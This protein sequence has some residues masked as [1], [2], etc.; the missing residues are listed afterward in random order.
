[1]ITH[2]SPMAN[3]SINALIKIKNNNQIKILKIN[4]LFVVSTLIIHVDKQEMKPADII[5]HDQLQN[6]IALSTLFMLKITLQNK[7]I[8]FNEEKLETTLFGLVL[9]CIGFQIS[10]FELTITFLKLI[11]KS[12]L[13]FLK[14][15][16]PIM[17]IKTNVAIKVI[18]FFQLT[19]H[20]IKTNLQLA[21]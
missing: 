3:V 10:R 13:K 12:E 7:F 6:V 8:M 1:M 16:H 21:A 5:V 14:F 20:V 15:N 4:L 19:L 2:A 17:M 9:N 11:P 18:T